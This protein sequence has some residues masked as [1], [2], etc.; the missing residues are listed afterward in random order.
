MNKI[1][2]IWKNLNKSKR[3]FLV[4]ITLIILFGVIISVVD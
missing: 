4:G 2:E 1:K 3:L